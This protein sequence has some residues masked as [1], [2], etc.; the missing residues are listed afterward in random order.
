MP[1]ASPT[2]GS[3]KRLAERPQRIPQGAGFAQNLSEILQVQA[4]PHR[5]PDQCG[6]KLKAV[7]AFRQE[8]GGLKG[9][10]RMMKE[11]SAPRTHLSYGL[12]IM[13]L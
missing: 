13:Y 2:A 8:W 10:R 12:Y 6:T 1:T 3:L 7:E 11:P 4:A 9:G 5:V